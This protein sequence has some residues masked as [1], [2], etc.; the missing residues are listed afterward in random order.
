MPF[1]IA[2]S[3]IRAANSD[4]RITGNNIANASTTGFKESR[5]QFGDV[6][7]TS[8][9]GSGI[10]Q[11]GSGVRT[12]N[13][14]QQ[15]TQG[16]ISFTDNVLDLAVSGTGYF[17]TSLNGEQMF[18]RA[19][20][21]SVDRDGYMVNN[22]N[23]R[24]QGYTTNTNG[25]INNVL[26]DVQIQTTSIEPQTTT[27]VETAVN[28]DSSESVIQ[29]TGTQY[30]S[31][32][33]TAAANANG[34]TAQTLV[35]TNPTGG[36]VNVNSALND[37]SL[38]TANSL[39]NL[40]GVTAT[41]Q[42]TATIS[43][44]TSGLGVTINGATLTNTSIGQAT[45]DEITALPGLTATLGVG[46]INIASI[47]GDLIFG[48]VG[49]GAASD[50]ILTVVGPT[51]GTQ[52]L[53]VDGAVDN[54][55]VGNL[56]VS[57]SFTGTTTTALLDQS[58]SGRFIG[59]TATIA[60]NISGAGATDHDFTI[61]VDGVASAA[62]I[63]LPVANYGSYAAM[64]T[65]LQAAINA[66]ANISG[67][68]VRYDTDHFVFTSSTTGT[69][70]AVT[71]AA[72]GTDANTLGIAGGTAVTGN[73]SITVGGI[74]TLQLDDGYTLT[75]TSATPIFS[76]APTTFINNAFDPV[77]PN[78]YNHSTS[79]TIYDSLGNSHIMQQ[80]FIKQ[81]ETA[82]TIPNHWQMVVRVD[83][84]DVGD[85]V[86]TAP[87]IP[88]AATYN[89]YFDANGAFDSV[90][91]DDILISNWVPYN[92][93][94]TQ[95]FGALQPN[96]QSNSGAL[97]IPFP[98]T[99]SNF[100]I[101]LTDSSQN[102]SNFEVRAVDQDGTATGRLASLNV[103]DNGIIFAR[104]TN[105]ENRALAQVALA[106]FPSSQGLQ[107]LGDTSWAQTSESGEPAIG[108]PGTASLGLIQSGALEESNVELSEQLVN[109]II[110][111][112]NFQAS[113]KTIETADQIT[114]TIINLR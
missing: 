62:N 55:T 24:L 11:V 75:D 32:G 113:A 92:T 107:P 1:N 68:S 46:T 17:V 38:T 88:T 76:N 102:S 77:D 111:Q 70:S 6:Y 106:N 61:T 65:A 104:F 99:S 101:L 22:I 57:G 50:E 105:G 87:T 103:D 112:R 12:Q 43:A 14:A 63:S 83:G 84:R 82:T 79:V 47:I 85:P 100:Q 93:D 110:A 91:S 89:L 80:F 51:G 81:P 2:L 98:P 78:T 40:A 3:G 26:G 56:P 72:V 5:A 28:L 94:G 9:L 19:G 45:V 7:S 54:T 59:G 31:A 10:N 109:L 18:T 35:I 29:S 30:I 49:S 8:V 37:N 86:I 21:F 44:W 48:V 42:A 20:T 73:T 60:T 41:T 90:Q 67:V 52:T 97:P 16:N 74:M 71:L 58:S 66:D 95:V 13:I 96:N 27:L 34:Y 23:S 39:N 53:E 36:T 4:L 114:Q 15:F 64:A 108:T 25:N 33:G 69:S